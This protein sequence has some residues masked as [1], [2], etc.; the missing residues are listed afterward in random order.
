MGELNMYRQSGT[1]PYFSDIA[2]RHGIDC[3]TVART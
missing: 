1:K 2:R 3:K